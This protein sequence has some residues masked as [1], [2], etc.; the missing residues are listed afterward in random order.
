VDS[1]GTSIVMIAGSNAYFIYLKQY[2]TKTSGHPVIIAPLDGEVITIAKRNKPAVIILE[3]DLAESA[4]R[5]ILAALK[6]DEM[7][8]NVPVIVCSWLSKDENVLAHEVDNYLQKPVSYGKF[9]VA[10]HD[11]MHVSIK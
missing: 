9:L 3:S 1:S 11:V 7:T 5:D 4:S 2:Y 8:R 6:L 10:L